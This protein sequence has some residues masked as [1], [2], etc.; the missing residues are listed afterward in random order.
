VTQDFTTGDSMRRALMSAEGVP[1]F[2]SIPQVVHSRRNSYEFRDMGT[3][4]ALLLIA[5]LVGSEPALAQPDT[6]RFATFNASLHRDRAGELIEDLSSRDDPQARQVAEIVQ[7][8][9][10]DVLLV[11]E[12]D[13]DPQGKAAA[14]FQENYLSVAQNGQ[15]AIQFV[16]RFTAPVNTGVPSGVDLDRDGRT[17]GL[18][19]NLGFGR[20]P[21]QYGLVVYSRYPIDRQQARTFQKFLWKDMPGAKLP[22]GPEGDAYYTPEALNV[23][24]LS[25]KSFWDLPIRIGEATVHFLVS[26]P[27]PPV[28]DGLEDR[29][30]CRNHDEI[31]L[32]ADY[33]DPQRS[34]HLYDDQGRRGGLPAGAKFVIAGDMNADPHDGDSTDGAAGQLTE[35]PL[36]H[37]EPIPA[38]RGGTAQSQ[39]LGGAN[40]R[41]QGDP[42]HDTSQFGPRAP[43]N[44]RIDYV[45]P[46]RTLSPLSAGI[47]WPAPDEP[48]HDLLR[49]SDHRL[50]W[51]DIRP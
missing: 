15:E 28:F 1:G 5:L 46:S 6:L 24:R 44:L 10:P 40:R 45:L 13:Y 41:H 17:N 31:R 50:V 23:L 33:A 30:G 4:A 9:R 20:F 25:S 21:G 35:H 2:L 43:G 36:V 32:A 47:F 48:G 16:E 26:H 51:V 7:R 34:G 29:N 18:G 39:A 8:V 38:S 37:R 19:D 3:R 12:F 11:N 14:Q 42:A 22:R 49:C 27:T